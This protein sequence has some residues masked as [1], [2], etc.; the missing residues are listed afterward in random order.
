MK[1]YMKYTSVVEGLNIRKTKEEGMYS[2]F[3]GRNVLARNLTFYGGVWKITFN[4]DSVDYYQNDDGQIVYELTAESSGTRKGLMFKT[5]EAELLFLDQFSE[6]A[7]NAT[8][9]IDLIRIMK[10]S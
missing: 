7:N 5:P 4:S 2:A 8:K 9:M 1:S 10:E 6:C 3:S